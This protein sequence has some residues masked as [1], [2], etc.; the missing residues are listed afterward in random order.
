[1]TFGRLDR[2]P[3]KHVVELLHQ[4]MIRNN[5][6]VLACVTVETKMYLLHMYERRSSQLYTPLLQLRKERLKKIQACSGF[7]LLTSVT[8][9]QRSTNWANKPTGS[10]SLNWFV[11]NPWKLWIYENHLWELRVEELFENLLPSLILFLFQCSV[12]L[13]DLF[14]LLCSDSVLLYDYETAESMLKTLEEK[15]EGKTLT[16]SMEAFKVKS[17][18]P[19][20]AK[21]S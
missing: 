12:H 2:L 14:E 13:D 19:V 8:S 20:R 18:L 16:I 17:L 9:V 21:L 11:I 6:H 10:R 3:A 5:L 4:I 1:M 15:A 7:E